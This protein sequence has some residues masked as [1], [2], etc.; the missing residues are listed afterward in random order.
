MKNFKV[1]P[2]PDPTDRPS[3]D[4]EGRKNFLKKVEDFVCGNCGYKVTG[5]GYTDHCPKCLWGKHM[6]EEIPG[7]RAAECRGLME[8]MGAEYVKGEYKIHYKCSKC[9][10]VFRVRIGVGDD[11]DKLLGLLK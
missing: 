11:K 7:D 10:H 8:P 5:D 3:L 2:S 9:R 6:D 1:K 4:K